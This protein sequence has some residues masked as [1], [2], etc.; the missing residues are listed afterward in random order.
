[1]VSLRGE[2]VHRE[3]LIAGFAVLLGGFADL[4]FM[5]FSQQSV[6]LLVQFLLVSVFVVMLWATWVLG[7]HRLYRIIYFYGALLLVLQL[8]LVAAKVLT[9]ILFCSEHEGCA[10]SIV[11]YALSILGN[12]LIAL[13]VGHALIIAR[14]AA[15]EEEILES[16][17]AQREQ[18]RL[19]RLLKKQKRLRA[20]LAH[21]DGVERDMAETIVEEQKQRRLAKIHTVY[22]EDDMRLA[23]LRRKQMRETQTPQIAYQN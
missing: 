16:A 7:T 2:P 15:R 18:A 1:M 23:Y 14:A 8:L 11:F 20:Q 13:P 4:V 5:L 12:L 22:S 9:L 10:E 17:K 19:Q 6:F 3:L 21:I